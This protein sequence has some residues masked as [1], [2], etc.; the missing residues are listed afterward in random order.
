MLW[1]NALAHDWHT[2]RGRHIYKLKSKMKPSNDLQGTSL[3]LNAIVLIILATTWTTFLQVNPLFV[4]LIYV[5]DVKPVHVWMF[6]IQVMLPVF[7]SSFFSSFSF[8]FFQALSLLEFLFTII[9]KFLMIRSCHNTSPSI[10]K[11]SILFVVSNC[12]RNFNKKNTV[13]RFLLASSQ[14]F[15]NKIKKQYRPQLIF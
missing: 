14:Y 13:P 9:I 3:I 15:L 7:S 11:P 4:N 6:S 10:L 2:V 8:F 1:C 12:Y 5:F